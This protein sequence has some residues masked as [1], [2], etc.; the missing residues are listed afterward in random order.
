VLLDGTPLPADDPQAAI[1]AGLLLVP[2]DRRHHGLILPESVRFNF[3]LPN[4]DQVSLGP[5]VVRVRERDFAGALKERLRVR[6][7]GIGQ[8]VGLLSGGNQ[9][10]VV[11]GKWLARKP[12]VLICDEPTRGVDVGA[13]SE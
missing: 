6:A 8:A 12:R 10:K 4:L 13:R 3:S 7:A 1:R 5:V 2:E 9:Q 11:L